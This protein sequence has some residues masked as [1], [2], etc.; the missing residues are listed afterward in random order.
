MKKIL[1]V[2][3]VIIMSVS[4]FSCDNASDV[5]DSNIGE[6]NSQYLEYSTDPDVI[7]PSVLD[8]L[9]LMLENYVS[10]TTQPKLEDLQQIDYDNLDPDIPDDLQDE[11]DNPVSSSD[12]AEVRE[13]LVKAFDNTEKNVTFTMDSSEFSQQMLYELVYEDIYMEEMIATMGLSSYTTWTV[14]NPIKNEVSVKLE[15]EYYKGQISLQNAAEMKKQTLTEAKRVVR[16]LDLANK[17]EYEK[18]YY[19]NQYLCDICV[20]TPDD[21]YTWKAQTAYGTLLEGSSVCEGYA[22]SA[23]LLFSLCDVESFYV[24]GDTP[25]GGHAWNIVRVD[26][27]YYQL[28][29][30]WND[31]DIAPN[32]YFLVTDDFMSLSR[33]WDKS[34]YPASSDTPY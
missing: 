15:F 17:S 19:I 32:E 25:E 30:T 21:E 1:S 7:T 9:N 29:S 16:E 34:R 26:G 5:L 22:R 8:V 3:L 18:V 12:M 10:G 14:S 6:L 4:L 11:A 31:T 33:T 23:Q 24:V 28:D 27:K 2:L 13:I 20:Y